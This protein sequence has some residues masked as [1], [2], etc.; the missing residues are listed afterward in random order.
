MKS[1]SSTVEA[2]LARRVREHY[3]ARPIAARDYG[4]SAGPSRLVSGDDSGFGA[5]LEKA[6]R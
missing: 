1:A 2:P 6:R 4:V 5:A 3:A